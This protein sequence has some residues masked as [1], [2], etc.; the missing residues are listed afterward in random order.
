M[1][2]TTAERRKIILDNFNRPTK[3]I[4]LEKLKEISNN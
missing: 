4:E 2:Y 1:V 3:Q